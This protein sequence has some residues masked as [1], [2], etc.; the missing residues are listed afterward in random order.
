MC[1]GLDLPFRTGAPSRPAVDYLTFY[2]SAAWRLWR[3]VG[4]GDV[5]IA[6]TDP[7]LISVV[8]AAVCRLRGARQV[9]W[10]QD[11]F[12]E[13][14]QA[15]VGGRRRLGFG[16]LARLRDASLRMAAANVVI[17]GRWRRGWKPSV[18]RRRGSG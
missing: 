8:A 12:P 7:P 3:L 9:N 15:F 4:P 14:A 10:L 18:F 13:V 16:L 17:G 5:V 1:T 6:K 11:L 2:L